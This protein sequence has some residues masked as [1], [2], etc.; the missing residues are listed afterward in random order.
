[1]LIL[2]FWD[3]FW[4][5]WA[6]WS[7]T[8]RFTFLVWALCWCATCTRLSLLR[9]QPRAVR[10]FAEGRGGGWERWPELAI[11]PVCTQCCSAGAETEQ[12]GICT[13][14]S[15]S[16]L[17]IGPVFLSQLK[18][19]PIPACRRVW[20]KAT[21]DVW[22]CFQISCCSCHFTLWKLI[23]EFKSDWHF[24]FKQKPVWLCHSCQLR[25]RLHLL[26][27]ATR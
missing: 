1:M 18:S 3:L 9:K 15:H 14:P 24:N 19:V 10:K 13:L 20:N 21:W 2:Y 6:D 8:K 5:W 27:R 17:R 7:V 11:C 26:I 22:F 16:A 25:G 4:F 12:A 23:K